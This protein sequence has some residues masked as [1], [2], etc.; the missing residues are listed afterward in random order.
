MKPIAILVDEIN[1]TKTFART[2]NL[3]KVEFNCKTL[4]IDFDVQVQT[5]LSRSGGITGVFDVGRYIVIFKSN[6][7]ES[8]KEM[9]FIDYESEQDFRTINTEILNNQYSEKIVTQFEKIQNTFRESF[10]KAYD[11]YELVNLDLAD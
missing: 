7:S 5:A 11:I 9:I 2:T 1:Q 4:E 6:Q 3:K 8:K 10:N